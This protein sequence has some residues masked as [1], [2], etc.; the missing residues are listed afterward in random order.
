MNKDDAPQDGSEN[1]N[2]PDNTDKESTQNNEELIAKEDSQVISAAE[3]TPVKTKRFWQKLVPEK[4]AHLIQSHK[5]TSALVGVLIIASAGSLIFFLQTKP[6]NEPQ[7]VA[8]FSAVEIPFKVVGTTP[9]RDA[10]N[11]PV[12][13]KIKIKFNRPVDPGKFRESFFITP[14]IKGTFSAGENDNEVVFEPEAS[15]AQGTSVQFGISGTL[16]SQDGQKL[17]ADFASSYTTSIP[18][19]GVLFERKGLLTTLDPLATGEK[20]KYSLMVGNEVKQATITAYKSDVNKLLDSLTYKQVTDNNYT[21][22]Q[23]LNGSISTTGLTSVGSKEN[24]KNSDTYE[25]SGEKG[26]FLLVATE[27]NKQLGHVWVVVSDFGVL[28]RQDDQK[29]VL[30]AQNFSNQSDATA[31]VTLYNLEGSVRQL[32]KN[33][34]TG[35]SS[36]KLGT[37]PRLDIAVAKSQSGFAV[38]PVSISE[39]L[40]DARL[41]HDLSKA[42]TTYGTTDKPTYRPGEKVEFA[43][44]ARTDNDANYDLPNNS[45]HNFYVARYDGEEPKAEF[46]ATAGTGGVISG[47]FTTSTN[48]IGEGLKKD[49]Y[50]IFERTEDKEGFDRAVASF[51]ITNEAQPKYGIEVKFDK[52]DYMPTDNITAKIKAANTDGSPLANTNLQIRVYSNNYYEGETTGSYNDPGLDIKE[53]ESSVKLDD[54]GIGSFQVDVSKLPAGN[55]QTITVL[56][57]KKEAENQETAGAG[58][59]IIHQGNAKLEFGTTR[60]N[61]QVNGT[62]VARVYAKKLDNTPHANAKLN[63]ALKANYFNENTKAYETKQ[64]AEGTGNTDGSGYAELTQKL[65][66]ANQKGSLE[67][68]VWTSDEANNKVSASTY[69]YVSTPDDSGYYTDLQFAALDVYG[70]EKNVKSGDTIKLTID[71]ASDIRALV[72][73]ERGRIHKVENLDLRQGKNTYEIDVS[74]ELSPSF[75][76]AISYFKDG[77]YFSEGTSFNVAVPDKRGAVAIKPSSDNLTA[78]TPFNLQITTKDAK[79]SNLASNIILGIADENMYRLGDSTANSMFHALY[80]PRSRTTNASSSLTGLGSGG[81]RC[82]GH[83]GGWQDVITPSGNA[84]LWRPNIRTDVAGA[85]TQNVSLPRGVWRVYVYS[86]SDDTVVGNSSITLNVN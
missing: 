75:A 24:I 14:H 78:N 74:S 12:H 20:A 81:G 59:T 72:T 84:A 44:F 56:A 46:K 30:S 64:I 17:G 54:Q 29:V 7:P 49:T 73:L 62:L 61:L 43:G 71:A 37:T 70:S 48:Y 76:L 8:R 33:T 34:V 16:E 52:S 4:L 60:T 42:S 18:S 39:S 31:E 27:Q 1:Q 68:V 5:R 47:S 86:M 80:S 45:T 32:A 67:L 26:V 36:I 69:Y 82:G 11:A 51:T 3:A 41:K 23:L 79:G 55:S 28:L 10:L 66:G 13:A 77:K 83:G 2:L 40:A 38:I 65:S 63:Y 6:S 15:I 19:Q 9:D 57:G 58:S 35:T 53:L 25:F 85:S 22:P 50:Q 21:R